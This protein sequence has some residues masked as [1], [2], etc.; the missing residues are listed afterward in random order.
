MSTTTMTAEEAFNRWYVVP[1]EKLRLAPNGDG[2]FIALQAA[3]SLFERYAAALRKAGMSKDET[4][5]RFAIEFKL[6]TA[7]G[8]IAWNV[9]RNGVAHGGMPRQGAGDPKYELFDIR[10]GPIIRF[11]ASTPRVLEADPWRIADHVLQLWKGNIAVFDAVVAFPR[12]SVKDGT[13]ATATAMLS[14]LSNYPTG[15]N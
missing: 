2:G 3:L 6:S 15:T 12:P 14:P 10:S 8:E 13:T 11:A 5:A 7:D 1:I 9:L 4:K